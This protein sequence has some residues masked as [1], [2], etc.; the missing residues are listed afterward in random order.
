VCSSG[1]V[2]FLPT[3]APGIGRSLVGGVFSSLIWKNSDGKFHQ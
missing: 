2:G 1:A 3:V